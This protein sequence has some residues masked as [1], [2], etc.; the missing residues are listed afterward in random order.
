MFF[1]LYSFLVEIY[2]G[3]SKLE[4][5]ELMEVT[6]LPATLVKVKYETPG[7][8]PKVYFQVEGEKRRR[9]FESRTPL[10]LKFPE[11][12]T[13]GTLTCKGFI[14]YS[15]TWDG[16]EVIQDAPGDDGIQHYSDLK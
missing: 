10:I 9:V 2:P 1:A 12:G 8:P 13:V 4:R 11:P 3:F 6:T 7:A 16:G 14:L 5:S 15:F